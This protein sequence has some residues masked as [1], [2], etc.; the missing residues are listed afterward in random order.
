[1]T[2]GL[3][4]DRLT[5]QTNVILIMT[6]F[7]VLLRPYFIGYLSVKNRSIDMVHMCQ[8][9]AVHMSTSE[10]MYRTQRLGLKGKRPRTK[11]TGMI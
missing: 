9:E 3:Q 10:A 2:I 11:G 8:I 6:M 4:I 7:L 5:T 1:M